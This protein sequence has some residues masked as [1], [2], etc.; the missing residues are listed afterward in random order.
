ME[1]G[2]EI[3]GNIEFGEIL[4]IF[5]AIVIGSIIYA[6][7]RR[8]KLWQ[9]GKPDNRFSNLNERI[10]A[11]I[12]T[13]VIDGAMH[14][15]FLGVLPSMDYK[16]PTIDDF[17]PETSALK[18]H[19]LPSPK[20]F[21]PRELNP[22]EL[23]PGLAHF[24]LFAGCTVLIL[25]A[26]LDFLSHYFFHFL[27]GKVY[28]GYSITVDS[29]GVLALIGAVMA[30]VRRYGKKPERLDNKTE[31]LVALILICAVIISGFIVEGFRIAATELRTTP[32]WA[33][34]SPGG[35]VIA[36][37]LSGLSQATLLAQ[38]EASW[39]FH[40][41]LS[42]GA[43]AYIALY[44]NRLWH[45]IISPLNVFFRS[46]G[47]R[48]A[49]VPINLEAAE[50]FGVSKV[51]DFTWKQ[52]LD[53]DACTRCGRCQDA[54][55][56][57]ASG[58][59]LNPKKVIQDIKTQL[60]DEAPYLLKGAVPNPGRDLIS[61]VVQ[62]D[63]IWNCTTCYACSDACPV[64]IEHVD[65]I[66][67]MRRNLVLERAKIPETAEGALRS[68]EARGHPWRGTTATRT[69]WAQ[70]LGIKTLAE[71]KNIDVLYWVGCTSA[72]EER[73]MKVAQAIAKVMK[74]AG[75]NF[76]ILGSEETC[77]GDPARR[78]GN[79]YLYQMQVQSNIE[80]FK[81]YGIK[82]IVTGCPHC[83]NTLKHEYPQFGGQYEVMH[84]SELIAQLLKEEKIR[85]IKGPRGNVVY[86]DAC[87]LGRYN[88]LFQPPREI[89]NSIPDITLVEF[90]R[91]RERGFCCGAGGGHMWLEEQKV[92]ERINVMRTE[93]A[94]A[95]KAEIVATACP[96]CLQMFQDGIKAKGAE[97]SVSPMDIAELVASSAVYR[98]YSAK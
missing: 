50:S 88:Y 38:H 89:L 23:Y 58:K 87:Y 46:L 10:R 17:T 76:G 21:I 92:G 5:G 47:P 57:Y 30:I 96:Y 20:D 44:W 49:L 64:T 24:L 69:D 19:K 7:Y 68:I 53:A 56:A 80:L 6:L 63:P 70:G 77:C 71:D 75:I 3:F 94:I 15:K 42:F 62:E 45:I 93:Q 82:K 1:P 8:Y 31:D 33:W 25:G 27:E 9:L 52:L 86:H 83:F 34:W 29:F 78:L 40:I 54:C 55:P 98:P 43:I 90:E 4:Y 79:E 14:R 35:Y 51:Q 37:S 84:H 12:K 36:R 67:A 59:P 16:R 13:S 48:G 11:F 73:S 39:W 95:V 81:N 74:L 26:F 72:L 41:V 28:L 32:D 22:R 85:I 66:V 61:E 91:N 65:K 60:L 97:E 2:R 18:V